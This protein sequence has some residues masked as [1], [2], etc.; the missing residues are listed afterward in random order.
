MG[1]LHGSLA[2]AVPALVAVIIAGCGSGDA[3]SPDNSETQTGWPG[4]L[5]STPTD[6]S[7][8]PT[9]IIALT[10]AGDVVVINRVKLTR[11]ATLASF[12]W[13]EDS[14]TGIVY[15]R[16]EDLTVLPGGGVLVSTC[17]EPA[18]GAVDLLDEAGERSERFSGWDPQVDPEGARVAIGGIPGIAIH[19]SS[20]APRPLRL[21]EADPAVV[22]NMPADPS[23]SPDGRELAFTVGGR[24]GVVTVTAA[25][26]AEAD[27]LEPDEGTHWSSPV[28]TAEGIVAVEQSGRWT[29]WPRSGPSRL[30]SVD[31]ETGEAAELASSSGPI[32]D[33]SVDPSGRHLLWVEDGRLRWRINGVP[34]GFNGDFVAAA[35]LP[36]TAS[37]A[38]EAEPTGSAWMTE[39]EMTTWQERHNSQGAWVVG[40]FLPRDWACYKTG[41]EGLIRRFQLLSEGRALS[42]E[43]L[44][45]KAIALLEGPAPAGLFNPLEAVHLKLLNA[46]VDGDTVYLDFGPGIYATNSRGTCGGSSMAAQFVALVHHYFAE[47]RDVCVLV[48]GIPSGQDG[49]ALVFHDSVACP[50]PLRD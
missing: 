43:A 12:P 9:R 6:A 48:E 34:S 1:K 20:L 4:D 49:D 47:A 22:D 35:W 33:V 25:S 7:S 38:Q 23:W 31:L 21:L 19:D 16:A 3:A 46:Y 39:Q 37:T 15:G 44:L 17:C 40:F 29:S 30:L 13:E 5:S 27:I 10:A 50:I 8:P 2:L 26:L 36:E 32:T 28:Y 41:S 24:L 42:Q 14:E 45:G 11:E 18:G